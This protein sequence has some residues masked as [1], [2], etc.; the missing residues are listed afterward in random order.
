MESKIIV[1]DDN[2]KTLLIPE[3]NET[4]HSTKGAITESQHVF[5]KEGL[6]HANKKDLKIF[7]MGFGT[8]L[9]AILTALVSE[10]N[11]IT[12]DYHTIEAYPLK[13]EMV[14]Q[15]NYQELLNLN[16]QQFDFFKSSHQTETNSKPIKFGNFSFQKYISKIQDIQLENDFFDLI[17]YDAF[18]PKVQSELW[19]IPVLTIIY[20][21]MKKDGVLVTYCAQGQFKRNLKELGFEVESIPGPPGKREMTRAIKAV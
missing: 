17:Y 10:Q 5:I 13:W 9:N 18:G 1:T 3:L 7:E 20:N 15:L 21:S 2:S 8:G 11:Q 16:E 12:V 6:M 14:D 19:E 4:Y